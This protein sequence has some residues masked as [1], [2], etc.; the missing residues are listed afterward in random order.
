MLAQF[1][2]P[3][4]YLPLAGTIAMIIDFPLTASRLVTSHMELVLESKHWKTL[5]STILKDR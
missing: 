3:A 1:G 2:I 4:D 5:D